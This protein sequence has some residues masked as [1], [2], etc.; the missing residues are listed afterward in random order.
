MGSL[1][2]EK[3][4]QPELFRYTAEPIEY[5]DLWEFYQNAQKSQWVPDEIKEEMTKDMRGWQTLDDNVQHFIKH[6]VAFFA[7]SD[8]VVGEIITEEIQNRIQIREVKIW[9]NHQS[10]M[11]D[12]HSI[13]YSQLVNEYVSDEVERRNVFNAIKKYPSIKRKIDWLHK[14]VGRENPFRHLPNDKLDLL[15]RV[16]RMCQTS[17]EGVLAY[18]ENDTELENESAP[19]PQLENLLHL[20]LED[21]PVALAQ[22]ILANAIMEGVFFSGSF[23]AIFWI[24]HFYHGTLPGLAKA[25]EWISR[26]EGM[27]TNYAILLYRK[28]IVNHLSEFIVHQM[29]QEAVDI[30]GAFISDALP[31]NLKGMNATLMHQYIKFVADGLLVDLGYK[32]I[33]NVSNPFEFMS[34]QSISVRIPDFFIDQSVSEYGLKHDDG[35]NFSEDF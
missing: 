6:I 1:N 34:K 18:I 20:I 23:C 29:F 13:V 17:V 7:I 2:T 21:K 10:M 31:S 11:E 25:N 12:V 3:L 30:E 27:H 19:I 15:K 16:M 4:E 28:Y 26:D 32:R 9:Y 33:Y 35:L 5:K 8:G 14:W 24:N 22:V